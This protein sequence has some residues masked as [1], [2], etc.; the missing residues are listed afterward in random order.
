MV[1]LP[2]DR[3]LAEASPGFAPCYIAQGQLY[4][5]PG[6]LPTTPS[7]LK[8]KLLGRVRLFATLW[9]IRSMEFSRPEYW[10]G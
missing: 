2:R 7:L 3:G 4:G 5:T 9:T 10:S 8:G 1:C 6:C